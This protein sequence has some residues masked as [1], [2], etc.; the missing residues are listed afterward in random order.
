MNLTARKA[1]DCHNNYVWIARPNG[2]WT[3]Y[4][5]LAHNSV[6]KK[7]RLKVGDFVRAGTYLGDEG[8]VG[9]AM[10]KHVHFECAVPDREQPINSGDFL[11]DNAGG[12]RERDPQF[13]GVAGG[14]VRKNAKYRVTQGEHR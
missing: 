4:S 7:A 1:A 2:E 9:C 3:N 6:M 10:L 11:I 13:Y 8:D 5:H 14:T 12:K